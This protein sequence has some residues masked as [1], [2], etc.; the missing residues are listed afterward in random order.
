MKQEEEILQI[1]CYKFFHNTFPH[2]RGLL[3]YN[4]NNSANSIQGRRNKTLGLQKG[5][6]DLTIY[7]QG[8]TYNAEL[9]T[10]TTHPNPDQLSYHLLLRT[11]DIP[12]DIIRT[13][14]QWK[15]WLYS[16]LAD[17][18]YYDDPRSDKG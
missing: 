6:P 17:E 2:L 1:E 11:Q 18:D 12:T 5:R 14:P 13:L 10:P 9:K 16:I 4:L 7:Y 3:N 8:R 15:H